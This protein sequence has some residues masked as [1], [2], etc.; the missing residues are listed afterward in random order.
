MRY[1][2]NA[3]GFDDRVRAGELRIVVLTTDP[4]DPDFEELRPFDSEIIQYLA[5]D[6][7]EILAECHRYV[8]AR[9]PQAGELGASGRRDP[10]WLLVGEEEWNISHTDNERCE[11]CRVWRPRALGLRP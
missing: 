2:F 1:Q 3:M 7:G 6:S 8:R 11:D 10:K 4:A 5:V 9:G